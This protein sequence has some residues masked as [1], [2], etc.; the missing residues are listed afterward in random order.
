MILLEEV[1]PYQNAYEFLLF[2]ENDELNISEAEAKLSVFLIDAIDERLQPMILVLIH[3]AQREI[4]PEELKKA[5][6]QEIVLPT[7][8][9]DHKYKVVK[10]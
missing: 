9:K 6:L 3:S 5:I 1:C 8:F 7:H 2:D 10:E 4:D